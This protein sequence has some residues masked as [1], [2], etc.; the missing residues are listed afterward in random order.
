[1]C[2]SCGCGKPN[3]D[4]GDSRNITMND[5]SSAAQAAGTTPDQVAQNIMSGLGVRRSSQGVSMTNQS[6]QGGLT[7]DASSS[8]PT[9]QGP[10]RPGQQITQFGT[11]SGTAWQESQQM[12]RTGRGGVQT[13]NQQE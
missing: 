2:L 1:M 12:G 5:L 4:H 13:P 3:D 8:L 11:E 10:D 7:Q 6:A 9:D